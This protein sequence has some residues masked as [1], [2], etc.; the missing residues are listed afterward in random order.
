M[1]IKE[2]KCVVDSD[3]DALSFWFAEFRS[4]CRRAKTH[5]IKKKSEEMSCFEVLDVLFEA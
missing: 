5:K 4:G 2:I 3:P 1:L